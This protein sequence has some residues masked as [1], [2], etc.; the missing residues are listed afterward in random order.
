MTFHPGT[1]HEVEQPLHPF[2]GFKLFLATL[3]VSIGTLLITLDQ[4][5]ANVAL[6]TISGELGVSDDNGTWVITSYTV[7]NGITVPLAGWLTLRLGRVRLFCLS[8][9]LFAIM[10]FLCGMSPSFSML[11]SF[12]IL[13]G[14]VSGSLIPLSQ[15]LLLMLFPKQKGFA[16]GIWGLVVMV[17]PAIGPVLGGWITQSYSWRWIFYINVP[18]GI[19]AGI[20]TFILLYHYE[21]KRKNEPIDVIG[22]LLLVITVAAYQVM[23]DRGND[24]DWFRSNFIVALGV[25]AFIGFCFFLVWEHF[26]SYP[27]VDLSFFKSRNFTMGCLVIGLMAMV[28]FGSLV[29]GPNWVQAQ[30]G[31][32]PLWAGYSIALFGASSLFIFP[33]VGRFLHLMDARV[34]AAIGLVFLILPF[35]YLAYLSIW[36]PFE[37][38][39]WPRFY[40]GIGFAL[41]FVALTMVT[42]SGI[43][44]HKMPSAAGIFSF[45]RM[46]SVSAGVSISSAYFMERE[47]FF[48]SRYVEYVIPSNPQFQVYYEAL[49]TQLGLTG[50]HADA[51]TY[52]MVMNQAF[53][54]TFLEMCYLGGWVFV[55]LFVA[56]FF[57]RSPQEARQRAKKA[58]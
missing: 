19:I 50:L 18:L 15:S 57:F 40:Q 29:V 37:N 20:V 27:V 3:S 43:P 47:N 24:D 26:H 21:S 8:S 53:T 25:I 16:M 42:L 52:K 45:T 14:L 34:W 49:K 56:L 1:V 36:T 22:L 11:I 30:L 41:V 13:Q 44:E 46:M 55:F 33:L 7:A 10:S 4:F 39:A 35:F 12:R 32:T 51:F 48:Q 5:I 23:L 28:L 54:E 17:G 9:I 58:T 31:Y 6:P 38:L 2:F